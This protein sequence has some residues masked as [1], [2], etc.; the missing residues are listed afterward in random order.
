MGNDHRKSILR[1]DFLLPLA[2]WVFGALAVG[3]FSQ[4]PRVPKACRRDLPS[5]A[6]LPSNSNFLSDLHTSEETPLR[7]KMFRF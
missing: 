3:S 2:F 4:P 6:L 1:C 5:L 7:T